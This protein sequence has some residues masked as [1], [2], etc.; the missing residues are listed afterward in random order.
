VTAT[1]ERTLASD[2]RGAV[3]VVGIVMGALLVGAL[4]H[5]ASVGDAVIWRERMQDAAD[6]GAFENAVWHARGMNVLAAINIIMSMVLAV[7]VVWRIA[8]LIV[9][10]ALIVSGVFCVLSLGLECPVTA[11]LADLEAQMLA[12]DNRVATTVVRIVGA[13]RALE[14]VV[15][16]AT[17]LLALQQ[18][19]AHTHGAYAVDGVQTYSSSLIPSINAEGAK[20]FVSCI[21]SGK[22]KPKAEPEPKPAEGAAA[23]AKGKG[24]LAKVG[25]FVKD[26]L[27]HS[28]MGEG[29]SLPVEED[30]YKALC[31]KAGEFFLNHY[32]GLFERMGAPAPLVA[33]IDK[34]KGMMGKIIG[35]FPTEFCTPI[36]DGI[37]AELEEL[38]NKQA[39]ESCDKLVE[40]H[41]KTHERRFIPGP[42]GFE[43]GYV[44]PEDG[45]LK[46]VEDLKKSCVKV[47][48]ARAKKEASDK[49]L[50]TAKSMTDC[51]KPAKVWEYAMNGNVFMRSFARV[52]SA[53][54]LAQ[55]D[56][57]GVQIAD[58]TPDNAPGAGAP[59]P[60][61][62]HA[63]TYFDCEGDWSACS[64]KAMWALRWRARLR[65]VQPFR[66]LAATAVQ[67]MLASWLKGI[68]GA[69][70]SPLKKVK[71]TE[72]YKSAKGDALDSVYRSS[73]FRH[74]GDVLLNNPS[75]SPTIH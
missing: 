17:P 67:P 60:V 24:P 56:L 36:G 51:A 2:T 62:A 73:T 8:L 1:S 14:T 46:T 50:A 75:S 30:S 23:E 33:A 9:T 52:E 39:G 20:N 48:T 70:E 26:N 16:S 43:P 38:L 71:D 18:A 19:T 57:R 55:R 40:D 65:R 49:I 53:T 63:E 25:G 6:A 45:K 72:A 3:L 44:D 4:W 61:L 12:N 28:R 32:A 66:N 35:K 58:L 74:A 31:G 10:V 59:D 7:L 22:P 64:G 5:I 42:T 13:A 54:P 69:I 41:T 29:V 15:A 47:R 11:G 34:V 37:S 27:S 68:I 21:T